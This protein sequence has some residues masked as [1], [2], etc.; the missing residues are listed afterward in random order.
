MEPQFSP[1]SSHHTHYALPATYI[2]MYCM[3]PISYK[4]SSQYS[5]KLQHYFQSSVLGKTQR[6]SVM[7]EVLSSS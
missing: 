5:V 4:F 6:E 7:A 2:D 3:F 1:L